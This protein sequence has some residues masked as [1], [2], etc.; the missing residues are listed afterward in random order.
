MM[1]ATWKQITQRFEPEAEAIMVAWSRVMRLGEGDRLYALLLALLLLQATTLM[2]KR[3]QR[4]MGSK[5]QPQAH[6][7]KTSPTCL[8][9][10]VL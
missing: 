2:R 10:P 6:T 9:I 1:I 5:L 7:N 8:S 4:H 3:N